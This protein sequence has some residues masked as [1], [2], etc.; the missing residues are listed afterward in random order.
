MITFGHDNWNLVLNM[1][2]G[3]RNSVKSLMHEEISAIERE[4]FDSKYYFELVPKRTADTSRLK[5]YHF[6]DFAPK[7]FHKIRKFYHISDDEYLKSIGPENLIG[8]LLM[9][10]MFSL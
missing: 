4:D 1:M 9:G 3:I 10:N 7:V 8:N 6:F 5:L 2:L